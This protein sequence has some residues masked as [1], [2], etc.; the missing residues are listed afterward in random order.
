LADFISPPRGKE[1]TLIT[2]GG[3]Q[4]CHKN[5]FKAW[6]PAKAELEAVAPR[7]DQ[8]ASG[9]SM[10]ATGSWPVDSAI[11]CGIKQ[12]LVGREDDDQ[13]EGIEAAE[14]ELRHSLPRILQLPRRCQTESETAGSKRDLQ[15]GARW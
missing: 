4:L 2:S 1:R 10:G 12:L 5:Y 3:S 9:D 15:D 7:R 13:R 6:L 14:E 8:M 11:E